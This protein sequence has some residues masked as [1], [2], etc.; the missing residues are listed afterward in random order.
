M[1]KIKRF[2]IGFKRFFAGFKIKLVVISSE[3]IG[4][5]ANVILHCATLPS[6]LAVSMGLS[7]KLPGIDIVLLIWC[8]LTLLFIKAILSKDMV[9]IITIGGG[10]IVQAVLMASIF[11][12]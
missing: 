5:V 1:E 6:L 4:W 2:L 12:K 11:F 9:N 7:D 3:T 8:A 10:F